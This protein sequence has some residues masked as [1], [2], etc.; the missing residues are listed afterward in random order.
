MA[1]TID[2]L[3]SDPL[4]QAHVAKRAREMVVERFSWDRGIDLLETVLHEV[5]EGR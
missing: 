4:L 3:L 1:E 2:L 5:V